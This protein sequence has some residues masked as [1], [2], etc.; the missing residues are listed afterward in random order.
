MAFVLLFALALGIAFVL[1]RIRGWLW[2]SLSGPVVGFTLFILFDAY[3]LPYRG[4]GASMWPIAILFGTPV[5]L[6]GAF[7]GAVAGRSAR[8][9]RDESSAS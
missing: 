2:L 3:V 8:K 5:A 7:L 6:L 4:G 1:E 9:A